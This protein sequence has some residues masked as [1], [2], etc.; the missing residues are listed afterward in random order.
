[1]L[2]IRTSPLLRAAPTSRQ[3]QSSATAKVL[4]AAAPSAVIWTVA[5]HGAGLFRWGLAS[6]LCVGMQCAA[7]TL[8]SVSFVQRARPA[9]ATTIGGASETEGAVTAPG[10]GLDATKAGPTVAHGRG[11]KAVATECLPVT[12]PEKGASVPET[13]R[14]CSDHGGAAAETP[15]PALAFGEFAFFLML[16]PSLVCEPRLLVVRARLPSRVAAAC[17]EFLHAALAFLAV[18]AICSA[19][20]TP[21]MRVLAEALHAGGAGGDGGWADEEEWAELRRT[22]GSG[23]WLPG[24]G[25]SL[26][27]D[28]GGWRGEAGAGAGGYASLEWGA[29]RSVVV[30]ACLGTFVCSPVINYLMFYAFFHSVCLGSA[31]LWGYPDRNIYGP[32]WLVM[33]DLR[34]YFRLWSAPV[35]RWLSKSIQRPMIEAGQREARRR[36]LRAATAEQEAFDGSQGDSRDD[37]HGPLRQPALSSAA[38]TDRRKCNGGGGGEGKRVVARWWF[39]SVVCSFLV[40]G[41]LHEAVALVAMRRTFWPFSTFFLALSASLM[42]FWDVV[43]PVIA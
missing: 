18:H 5:V 14:R 13:Q 36:L 12:A 4:A 30:A 28:W 32:W 41:T 1:M 11:T 34:D 8:K 24:G 25:A 43:F 16:T 2:I 21:A 23:W 7:L 15:T 22:D 20:Y 9:G 26:S 31:E 29:A 10:L 6:G 19:L 42:P 40:S 27:K 38:R 17:S 37:V 35:H 3:Y 39:A 33:D